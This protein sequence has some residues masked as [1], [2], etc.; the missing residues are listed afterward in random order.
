MVHGI[1]CMEYKNMD[2]MKCPYCEYEANN[3]YDYNCE[4]ID[5]EDL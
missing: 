5:E 3:T 1:L 2:K 4:K